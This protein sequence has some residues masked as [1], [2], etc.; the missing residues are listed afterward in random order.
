MRHREWLLL[1]C[2]VGAACA[3]GGTPGTPV[4]GPSGSGFEGVQQRGAE[5]MGVD[6]S[7]SSHVFESLPDGG[8]IVLRR[9]V[10]DSAG[11]ATIRAHMREIAAQFTR[12]DFS[13][14]G[15]V[16]ARPVPGTA[17]MAE[18]RALIRYEASDLPRG[19]Q[20]RITTT[21]PAAV[22]AVHEFLAFQRQ[23]HRA[24]GHDHHHHHADSA[25]HRQ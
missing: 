21:D 16:H 20:V 18:R 12:G 4:P 1:S 7:T 6:Q 19:G 13:L 10:E 2:L 3:R 8:R 9:D 22:A 5:A 11:V 17:V 24:P 25:A 23:D 14:P 15:F